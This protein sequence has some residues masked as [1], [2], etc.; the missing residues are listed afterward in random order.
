MSWC[1]KVFF[2][3]VLLPLSYN[4]MWST[5]LIF[6][7]TSYKSADTGIKW[8]H[9]EDI[10]STAEA[11]DIL[12]T[13]GNGNHIVWRGNM[14]KD[15]WFV[16]SRLKMTW[17]Q[18]YSRNWASISRKSKE[19]RMSYDFKSFSEWE[20]SK[21]I[22]FVVMKETVITNTQVETVLLI[23]GRISRIWANRSASSKSCLRQRQSQCKIQSSPASVMTSLFSLHFWK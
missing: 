23:Y 8:M 10:C 19:K 2:T 3:N 22:E 7:F 16:S 14:R 11:Q 13:V 1:A 12:V 18:R 21:S 4:T 20:E 17:D 6:L 5:Q 9:R 15:E